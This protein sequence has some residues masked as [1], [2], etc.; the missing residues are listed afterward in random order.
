MNNCGT[1]FCLFREVYLAQWLL[2][3][4]IMVKR[5]KH[6]A[7][8]LEVKINS[9]IVLCLYTLRDN[10]GS[11]YSLNSIIIQKGPNHRLITVRG[12]QML[13][14]KWLPLANQSKH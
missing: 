8:K 13:S 3:T 11:E 9:Y 4:I 10:F 2:D 1:I 7:K 6:M 5:L 12:A 14:P